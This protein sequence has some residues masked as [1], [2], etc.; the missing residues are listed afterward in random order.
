MCGYTLESWS[1]AYCFQVTVAMACGISSRK[2][3]LGAYPILLEIG[4]SLVSVHL[5][6]LLVCFQISETLWN[7]F[8]WSADHLDSFKKSCCQLQAKV[9]TRSTG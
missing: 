3:V 2:I 6:H 8:I 9:C 7:F 1:V 5:Y 4:M